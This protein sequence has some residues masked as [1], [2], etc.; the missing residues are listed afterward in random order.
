MDKAR[1]LGLTGWVKNLMDGRVEAV[2][3][4]DEEKVKAAVDWLWQGSPYSRIDNVKVVW[5]DYKG[6]FKVFETRY[7]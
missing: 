4:G 2:F 3:E 7:G 1:E 5:E 6:V